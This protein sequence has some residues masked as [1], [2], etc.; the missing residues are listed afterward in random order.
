MRDG[1]GVAGKL[2]EASSQVG[3]DTAQQQRMLSDSMVSN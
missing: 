1:R 3:V 2:T